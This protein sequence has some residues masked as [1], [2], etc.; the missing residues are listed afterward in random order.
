MQDVSHFDSPFRNKLLRDSLL[1]FE[2]SKSLTFLFKDGNEDYSCSSSQPLWKE[3]RATLRS[4]KVSLLLRGSLL[5][6]YDF[7]FGFMVLLN[8]C[9]PSSTLQRAPTLH[10]SRELYHGHYWIRSSLPTDSCFPFSVVSC[11]RFYL[12]GY[13]TYC[14]NSGRLLYLD[15]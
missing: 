9:Q 12:D 6:Y 14:F 11:I 8:L 15:Y 3:E 4:W 5:P 7:L 13:N 1:T 2:A 10:L